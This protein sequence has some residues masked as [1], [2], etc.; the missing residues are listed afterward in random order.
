[1][2]LC[3][4]IVCYIDLQKKRT[5]E[6]LFTYISHMKYT[7]QG[8]DIYFI[9]QENNGFDYWVKETMKRKHMIYVWM[10]ELTYRNYRYV[11]LYHLSD[12]F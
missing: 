1:M 9:L 2:G 11:A 12:Y 3:G 6:L 8:T 10:N 5:G 7:E 4:N